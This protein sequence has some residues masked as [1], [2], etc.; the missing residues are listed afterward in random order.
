[1][2]A[3]DFFEIAAE[4]AVQSDRGTSL[5]KD[6]QRF[7]E[8][9]R[10]GCIGE[11]QLHDEPRVGFDVN[12]ISVGRTRHQRFKVAGCLGARNVND[13]HATMINGDGLF[14]VVETVAVNASNIFAEPQLSTT[15]LYPIQYKTV[16][17]MRF[18]QISISR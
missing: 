9:A 13:R 14:D 8:Q 18:Q 17:I 4:L 16:K 10:A 11:Q 5:F 12:L 7:R 1:M 2:A 3:D 15:R 6:F